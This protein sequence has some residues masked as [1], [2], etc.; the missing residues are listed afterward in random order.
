MTLPAIVQLTPMLQAGGRW[1]EGLSGERIMLGMKFSRASPVCTKADEW[2]LLKDEFDAV[3]RNEDM[4]EGGIQMLV[5][6]DA[7]AASGN[8]FRGP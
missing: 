5:D 8:G 4:R 2:T 6:G 1:P 3:V 7:A